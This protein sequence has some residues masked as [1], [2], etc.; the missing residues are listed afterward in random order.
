M[1]E[2][3]SNNATSTLASGI[4]NSVTSLSVSAGHGTRWPTLDVGDWCWSTITDG[5]NVEIVKVTARSTDTFTVVRGQQGTTAQSWSAGATIQM[6]LTR[7][8]LDDLRDGG[9]RIVL[10]TGWNLGNYLQSAAGVL[11]GAEDMTISVMA[12]L[13]GVQNNSPDPIIITNGGAFFGG[14][15][16]GYNSLRPYVGAQIGGTKNS[17]GFF[18]PDWSPGSAITPNSYGFIDWKT[19]IITLRLDTGVLSIHIN[20]LEFR[21]IDLSADG[22]YG[23]GANGMR[24]GLER[25]D[26]APFLKGGIAGISYVESAVAKETLWDW[27]VACMNANDVIDGGVGW[28]SLYSFKQLLLRHGDAVP[29]TVEDLAGSADL[30]KTGTLTIVE[31]I[32]RWL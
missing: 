4:N 21:E 32:P 13:A 19:V 31:E 20:G 25:N 11:N 9:G 23:P 3:F 17:T 28:S 14:Y 10:A 8:S 27:Q 2:K 24:V 1:G 22:A 15:N 16:I 12:R 30:T 6:R 7:N 29:A 5:T 18:N 26:T